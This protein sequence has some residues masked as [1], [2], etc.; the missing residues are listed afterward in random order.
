MSRT[1]RPGGCGVSSPHATRPGDGAGLILWLHS[2]EEDQAVAEALAGHALGRLGP[3]TVHAFEFACALTLG[4]EGLPVRN[5]S[6]TRRALEAAGRCPGRRPPRMAD[7]RRWWSRPFDRSQEVIAI[8]SV[9]PFVLLGL[10]LA[11]D[12]YERRLLVAR[13]GAEPASAQ[14]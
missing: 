3:R 9:L 14:E 11:L 6:A 10:L 8:V 2:E 1:T 12:R 7:A 5:R 4:L 13:S